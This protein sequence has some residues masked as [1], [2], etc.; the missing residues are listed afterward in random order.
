MWFTQWEHTVISL[1]FGCL[2][3]SDGS[4]DHLEAGAVIFH[5]GQK[6]RIV[7]LDET[8]GSLDNTRGK[9]GGRPLLVFY[10]RD[11]TGGA[12]A[13]S[14]LRYSPTIICGSNAEGDAIPPHFQLKILAKSSHRERFSVEFIARCNDVWG[15]FG[16]KC[17][18]L[19]PC[20][21]GLN[22]KA[23]MNSIELDK[24]FKRSILPLH[25][26]IEDVPLK[27][28]I[29]KLDSGPGRM[30]LDMLAHFRI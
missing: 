22:D 25:P 17:P 2:K 28:V 20:A 12:T 16:H 9:R 13:A 7:N 15:V 23:G 8:D 10:A 27:R 11:M 1:G 4:E 6:K 26:D 29:A 18:M 14:K 24:Y 21:F 5:D 30:N 3:L 19:L